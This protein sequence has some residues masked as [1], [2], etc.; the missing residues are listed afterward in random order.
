MKREKKRERERHRDR[1]IE[2]L[3]ERE[4][5]HE[6]GTNSNKSKVGVPVSFDSEKWGDASMRRTPPPPPPRLSVLELTPHW[7][8]R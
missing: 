6:E 5:W 2:R 3:R 1:Q 8:D 7:L 4:K